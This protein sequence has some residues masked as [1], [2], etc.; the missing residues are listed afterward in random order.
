MDA[1][2]AILT[3]FF[4]ILVVY[5]IS[6]VAHFFNDTE[7]RLNMI[8]KKLDEIKENLSKKN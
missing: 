3:I 1:V 4:F 8:E 7:I 2:G 5:L 6:R